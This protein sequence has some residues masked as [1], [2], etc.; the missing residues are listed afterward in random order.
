MNC[1]PCGFKLTGP[2]G[3]LV[4]AAYNGA[5]SDTKVFHFG[6]FQFTTEEMFSGMRM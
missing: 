2:E 6:L 4:L 3:E 1:Y 5:S